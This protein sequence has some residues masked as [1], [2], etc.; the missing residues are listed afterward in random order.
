[1]KETEKFCNH[2]LLSLEVSFFMASS[3]LDPAFIYALGLHVLCNKACQL[4]HSR[5]CSK[6]IHVVLRFFATALTVYN[7]HLLI[8]FFIRTHSLIPLPL[9]VNNIQK[10]LLVNRVKKIN[11]TVLFF[12]S[13]LPILSQ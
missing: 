3:A 2:S 12:Q 8:N 10:I 7:F 11:Y 1:M 5:S 6:Y 9:V 13:K 4:P